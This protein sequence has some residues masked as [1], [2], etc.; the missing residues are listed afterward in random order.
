MATR[1]GHH[2]S[3]T[4]AIPDSPSLKTPSGSLSIG[5]ETFLLPW[6]CSKTERSQFLINCS[7]N[8]AIITERL[9]QI[10]VGIKVEKSGSPSCSSVLI[11]LMQ[12]GSANDFLHNGNYWFVYNSWLSRGFSP[13]LPVRVSDWKFRN[14][15]L[16]KH[17]LVRLVW[18]RDFTV[19]YTNGLLSWM[20]L[21]SLLPHGSPKNISQELYD[22][23]PRQKGRFL[24]SF[25]MISQS[26]PW[27]AQST[28]FCLAIA[29]EKLVA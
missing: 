22:L 17:P 13:L 9:D 14:V 11:Q 6:K 4:Q 3:R 2:P 21:M 29:I 28:I 1:D 25:P 19:S 27:K 23:L 20:L 15:V 16:L 8:L 24:S 7:D 10:S 5:R 26:G 12:P 18:L